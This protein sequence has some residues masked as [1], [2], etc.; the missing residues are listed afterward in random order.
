MGGAK[1]AT[2]ELEDAMV[3]LDGVTE[4]TSDNVDIL[5]ES[6]MKLAKASGAAAQI[7]IADAIMK[8]G[9]ASKAAQTQMKDGM[10][11]VLGSWTMS[12]EDFAGLAGEALK[13]GLSLTDI[14]DGK[15]GGDFF[16]LKDQLKDMQKTL[17][18][19]AEEANELGIA[20]VNMVNTPSVKTAS[21]YQTVLAD[22]LKTAKKLTPEMTEY[23]ATQ[24]RLATTVIST[25]DAQEYLTQSQKNLGKAIE[26]TNAITASGLS[27]EEKRANTMREFIDALG[28]QVGALGLAGEALVMYQVSVTG[29]TGADA[30]EIEILYR[31]IQAFKDSAAAV[32]EAA[33]AAKDAEQVRKEV[34][35]PDEAAGE[36]HGV[37]IDKLQNALALE[38]I[39]R[40]EFYELR[41][42]SEEKLTSDLKSNDQKR[43]S[44]KAGL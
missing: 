17:G 18:L 43:L 10:D 5:T 26:D 41:I 8:A 6:Y 37:R 2:K 40:D 44:S 11:D 9:K 20:M 22:T 12:V 35:D 32:K 34:M 27:D 29:A 25:G 33:Q 42:A 15:G 1:D 38:Q 23:A 24:S 28:R 39:T 21:E 13:R 30:E 31:K 14:V 36:R 7:E 4:T 16:A 19:T 3:V